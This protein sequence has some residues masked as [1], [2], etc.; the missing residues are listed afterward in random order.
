MCV[1]NEDKNTA[2]SGVRSAPLNCLPRDQ[3]HE[4]L[5]TDIAQ[6]L[7]DYPDLPPSGRA[8]VGAYV[9]LHPEWQAD[10]DEARALAALLDAVSMDRDRAADL[11]DER[12]FGS[13]SAV[14]AADADEEA[15]LQ[16]RLAQL[17]DGLESPV[18]QFERLTGRTLADVPPSEPSARPIAKRA[19]RAA[20]DRAAAAPSRRVRTVRRVAVLLGGLFVA[21]TG[22]FA[23]S[24]QMTSDRARVADLES[25][26]TYA[27]PSVRGP[28]ENELADRLDRTLDSVEGARSSFLGLFPSYDSA[29][30]DIVADSLVAI[31]ADARPESS[32]AQEARLA[33]GRIRF[34]QKR[35]AE[36]VRILGQM[37]REGNYRA[38]DA[39]RLLDAMR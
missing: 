37:V 22:M 6:L 32:V 4:P 23:V 21:Y 14:E 13:A 10:L 9:E 27:P 31:S 19:P 1:P 39:R 16:A 26:P 20:A 25:L 24:S 29:A 17:S 2:T 36:A 11:V 35:D 3:S 15:R 34:E 38:S 8:Q 28:S 30:L 12:L 5:V 33:L 18:A 7:L